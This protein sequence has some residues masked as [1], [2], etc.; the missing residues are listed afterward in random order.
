[1]DV[2]MKC[3]LEIGNWG[4]KGERNFSQYVCVCVVRRDELRIGEFGVV[5]CGVVLCRIVLCRIV[6]WDNVSFLVSG[7]RDSSPSE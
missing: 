4:E 3:E 2:G 6:A 1:M 7:T 5:L